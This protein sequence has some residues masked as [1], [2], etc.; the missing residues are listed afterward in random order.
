MSL[1]L[2][3]LHLGNS[4]ARRHVALEVPLAVSELLVEN[5]YVFLPLLDPDLVQKKR[6]VH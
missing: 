6:I 2:F 1:A 5:S 4:V 3:Q